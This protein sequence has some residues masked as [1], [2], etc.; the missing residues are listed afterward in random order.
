MYPVESTI[1]SSIFP[2][3]LKVFLLVEHSL[4]VALLE[5]DNWLCYI[6]VSYLDTAIIIVGSKN[7]FVNPIESLEEST[8]REKLA[9]KKF[10]RKQC[11][12]E[13]G[14]SLYL[15][16]EGWLEVRLYS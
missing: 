15:P 5:S 14:L 12:G 9:Y 2:V 13:V 8:V 16:W 10:G 1:K 6:Y 11:E 3:V 4:I 7:Y